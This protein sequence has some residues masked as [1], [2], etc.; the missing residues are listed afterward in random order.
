MEDLATSEGLI[1]KL[2]WQKQ[3][4]FLGR[5]LRSSLAVTDTQVGG[6]PAVVGGEW[7]SNSLYGVLL[8]PLSF[9]SS[10]IFLLQRR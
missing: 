10:P 8:S 9:P 3:S 4:I 1:L 2:I 6:Q 7:A 5:Y